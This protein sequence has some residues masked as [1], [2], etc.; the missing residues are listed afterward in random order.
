MKTRTV[1]LMLLLT[2]SC[3]VLATVPAAAGVLYSNGPFNGDYDAWTINYGFSVSDSF[4]VTSNSLIQGLDFV[5][6][7]FP[8]GEKL[9][10]VD[11]Q[12]GSTSFGGGIQTLTGVTNT[13]LGANSYGY[14][15]YDASYTFAGIQWSGPG[16]VTLSNA[17]STSG[18]SVEPIYWDENM[19]WGCTSPGCPSIAYENANGQIPSETF[20]LAGS[21]GGGTTP[22]PGSILLFASGIVAVV[23][24]V[25]R[26]FNP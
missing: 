12:V 22:E 1:S 2:I 23:R 9:T 6:W 26:K 19:G 21:T 10:T 14:S 18:C 25:G 20:T 13:Y 11:M 7:V 8:D 3:I 17:C 5:Y 4:L 16:F 24:R 15:L